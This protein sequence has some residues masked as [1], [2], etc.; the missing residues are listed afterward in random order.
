M[1][2][3]SAATDAPQ[4]SSADAPTTGAPQLVDSAA[5]GRRDVSDVFDRIPEVLRRAML[6]RGFTELTEVQVAALD[7]ADA[8]RDLRIT[9]KTGSGK[10]VALGL[11]MAP[12]LVLPPPGERS[13]PSVLIIV[14]T[15]ELAAQVRK[16]LGW[17]YAGVDGVQLDSVTGGTSLWQDRRKLA[18]RPRV[19]VGT[20]GRLLDHIRSGELDVGGVRELVLDEADQM[21]DMG[22]REDLGAILDACPDDRRT[23][24]VS[25]TFPVG[26]QRLA[27][28]YQNDPLHVEGTRLGEANEDIEHVGYVVDQRS[29]YPALVNLLLLNEGQRT[30][31]FV[32]TRAETAELAEKLAKEGFSTLSLSGELQQDQRT[33]TLENFRNGQVSVLVATDVAARGLDVPDVAMVIHTEPVKNHEVYTHRSGR[34]G[35]AGQKGRSVL[36]CPRHRVWQAERLLA[37]ADVAIDWH[38]IPTAKKVRKTLAKNERRRIWDAIDTGDGRTDELVESA[39]RLL[40]SRDAV[41]VVATLL[42]YSPPKVACE[43][44]DV[45]PP[46]PPPKNRGRRAGHEAQGRGGPG[47]EHASKNR[48]PA[49]QS[50]VG[51]T[52]R[53]GPRRNGGGRYVRF[54][55]NY[56]EKAGANAKRLLAI[57]CRRGGITSRDV[58]TILVGP[59]SSAFEVSQWRAREFENEMRQPD[60]RDPWI[61]VRQAKTSI[62]YSS[63]EEESRRR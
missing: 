53:P 44:L 5:E 50:R 60:S 40:K 35:R 57:I 58:G 13:G 14:P 20:P 17:L 51:A 41:E 9:S 4:A 62:P 24:L 11:A 16:E 31:V 21:L 38:E 1:N 33:R 49:A 26:I 30:L 43:P 37:A 19:L 18:L 27:R 47:G 55:I 54:V 56:G 61:R 48:R 45:Q 25:A 39:R 6:D 36:F 63:F 22:F 52:K 34:T 2:L 10:T 15:R 23:H 8:A 3:S 12:G 32:N 42:Q 46:A 28:R 59:E 29:R 7:A